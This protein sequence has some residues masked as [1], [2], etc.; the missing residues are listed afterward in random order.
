MKEIINMEVRTELEQRQKMF[1]MTQVM[2]ADLFE[3]MKEGMFFAKKVQL[4]NK[5]KI[6]SIDNRAT[7]KKKEKAILLEL[8]T[9]K[10]VIEREAKRCKI[11][12]ESFVEYNAV[13]EDELANIGYDVMEEKFPIKSSK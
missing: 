6:N 12:A 11:L 8:K 4:N 5:Y 10:K 2:G 9:Y 3:H 1:I 7:K 13:L